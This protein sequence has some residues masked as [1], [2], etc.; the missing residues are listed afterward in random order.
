MPCYFHFISILTYLGLS[1]SLRLHKSQVYRYLIS[2]IPILVSSIVGY[3]SGGVHY[4]SKTWESYSP[5]K[6]SKPHHILSKLTKN[7]TGQLSQGRSNRGGF[8]FNLA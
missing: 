6:V 8:Q 4:S 7:V 2:L 5:D 3:I 1:S